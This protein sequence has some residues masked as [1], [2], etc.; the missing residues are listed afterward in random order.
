MK[1]T[2]PKLSEHVALA[3]KAYQKSAQLFKGLSLPIGPLS[4][5]MAD[6]LATQHAILLVK[7]VQQ[8]E[9]DLASEET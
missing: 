5:R 1:V 4:G 2:L 6:I 7:L 3:V 8:W 9:Q